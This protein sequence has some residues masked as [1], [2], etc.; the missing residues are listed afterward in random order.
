MFK[1]ECEIGEGS[2]GL[3]YK[4]KCLQSSV[5]GPEKGTRILVPSSSPL[6]LGRK[7]EGAQ[8]GT[9]PSKKALI[10]EQMYVMKYMDSSK[11]TEEQTIEAMSEIELMSEFES[12]YT[13]QFYDAFFD[14]T[15]IN[16][17]MEY[18]HH[19]DLCSYIKKQNG[20]YLSDNFIWKVFIHITLGLHYL[21]AQNIIHRDLKSLNV[22]L[23]KD[24]SAKLGD[25]GCARKLDA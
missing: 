14:D 7:K 25:F 15:E 10:A 3:I 6:I 9:D 23:T 11:I 8:G 13:V 5:P 17:V 22:F 16:I 12:P 2:F 24:N 19:G 4:V 18:C 20:K 21:H 1:K